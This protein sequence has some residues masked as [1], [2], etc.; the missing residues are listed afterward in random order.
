MSQSPAIGSE[1]AG[2]TKSNTRRRLL[3]FD[4]CA[5]WWPSSRALPYCCL[6][7]TASFQR[8]HSDDRDDAQFGQFHVRFL[9]AHTH[10]EDKPADLNHNRIN[11]AVE[12]V[13]GN[14]TPKRVRVNGVRDS[15]S[16]RCLS[17]H[18]ENSLGGNRLEAPLSNKRYRSQLSISAGLTGST[19]LESGI[20]KGRTI[21]RDI[22]DR[23]DIECVLKWRVR[24]ELCRALL[25]TL[26]LAAP[27]IGLK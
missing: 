13:R 9:V 21:K 17:P 5:L 27:R 6:S 16:A 22:N 19:H 26:F 24:A 8:V 12:Q 7:F 14:G 15:S 3:T 10:A 25:T 4:G 18:Q 23:Y 11:A 20:S 2:L 1:V